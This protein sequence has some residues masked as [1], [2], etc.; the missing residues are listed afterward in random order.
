MKR[1]IKH[2][3]NLF[4]NLKR[5]TTFLN[6]QDTEI[7]SETVEEMNSVIE[8]ELPSVSLEKEDLVIKEII[9]EELIEQLSFIHTNQNY[10]NEKRREAF[11][12]LGEL[13]KTAKKSIPVLIKKQFSHSKWEIDIA[14]NT[15]YKLDPLWYLEDICCLELDYL[16]NRLVKD[17]PDSGKATEILSL[18]GLPAQN[19][20]L[21]N[22]KSETDEY[23]RVYYIEFLNS[24]KNTGTEYLAILGQIILNSENSFLLSKAIESLSNFNNVSEEINSKINHFVNH[25]TLDVKIAALNTKNKFLSANW[26]SSQ[27]NDSLSILLF[28]CLSDDSPE[29]ANLAIEIL[30]KTENQL[31]EDLF[32]TVLKKKGEFTEDN[33][34]DFFNRFGPWMQRT[35]VENWIPTVAQYRNN[36]FWRQYEYKKLTEKPFLL[37]GNVLKILLRKRKL[38]SLGNLIIEILTFFKNKE[39]KHEIIETSINILGEES[40]NKH[41]IILILLGWLAHLS[42]NVRDAAISSLDKLNKEWLEKEES[43]SSILTIINNLNFDNKLT[44][45]AVLLEL[46]VRIIPLIN[47]SL[48]LT[49]SR[50]IQLSLL[51]ILDNIGAKAAE[52]LP[53]L[54]ILKDKVSNSDVLAEVNNL[55]AKLSPVYWDNLSKE[56]SMNISEIIEKILKPSSTKFTERIKNDTYEY[57]IALS[58]ASENR[59]YVEDIANI[60]ISKGHKVFYD[61]HEQGKLWGKDLYQYLNDIYKNKAKYCI[62]FISKPYAEKLWTKHEL[63]SAQ[64]RAFEE[65]K[66][67]I[68]PVRFDDSEIPGL[69]NTMAYIDLR[70]ITPFQLANLIVEKIK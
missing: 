28:R 43:V 11:E 56:K 52:T 32:I 21:Y 54:F 69:N 57:D 15:L 23:K 27:I 26:N 29:V 10:Q 67:Y 30:S 22:L 47:Q 68:L 45:K 7:K 41:T 44:C 8:S 61:K 42:K 5:K 16:I 36:E 70:G 65:N 3:A 12:K 48:C 40:E 33:W 59:K 4:S 62:V 38:N 58:F 60:V 34:V 31:I 53:T 1:V 51:E 64:A 39:N 25:K 24:K 6:S 14:V 66:E 17:K 19:A 20:I 63:K 55:I 49:E 9:I 18:I 2:I 46:N 35:E 37:L 13:G 50:V